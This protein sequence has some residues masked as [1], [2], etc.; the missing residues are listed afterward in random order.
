MKRARSSVPNRLRDQRERRAPRAREVQR[1]PAR[2]VDAALD[3]GDLQLR[4]D[5][6]LDAHEMP[7]P[8]EVFNARPEGPIAH[9]VAA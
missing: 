2:S 7:V 9:A 4:V 1:R 5:L 3:L 6:V 8:L